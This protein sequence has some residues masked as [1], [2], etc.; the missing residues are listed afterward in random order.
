MQRIKENS[1]E[2]NNGNLGGK[3]KKI[4]FLLIIVLLVVTCVEKPTETTTLGSVHGT[5]IDQSNNLELAGV[6]VS[7]QNVGNRTTDNNGYYE[8]KDLEEDIYTIEAEKAGYVNEIEQVEIEA[9]KSKIVN[10]TLHIAQPAQLVVSP[11]SLNFGQ[12]VYNLNISVNNGGDEEL[13]WQVSSDQSWLYTFPTTG[14]TTTETDEIKATVNRASL[15][16]GNY[17]GNLSFTSN[18]GDFN[19]PIQMVVTPV[20]MNVLPTELDFGES[21]DELIFTITAIGNGELN[22]ELTKDQNWI[23]AVPTSGTLTNNYEDIT[24]N[25]DRNELDPSTYEGIISIE[26]NAGNIN[27]SIYIIVADF[28]PPILE[29]PDNITESSMSLTWSVTNQDEI[30]EYRLYRSENPGVTQNSSLV[31]TISNPQLMF[32]NDTD[33]EDGTTYYYRVYSVS[34]FKIEVGSNEVNATTTIELGTWYLNTNLGDTNLNSVCGLNDNF[35]ITVGSSFYGGKIFK[36]NGINWQQDSY[37][38]DSDFLDIEII[39]ENNIW[40]LGGWGM[41]HYNGVNWSKILNYGSPLY[42]FYYTIDAFNE[43][44]IIFGGKNLSEGKGIIGTWDGTN[45]TSTLLNAERIV[46]VK[47]QDVNN[48]W[49]LDENGKVFYYNGYG[50]TEIHNGVNIDIYD[51]YT[52]EVIDNSEI[53]IGGNDYGSSKLYHLNGTIWEYYWVDGPIY[54]IFAFNSTNV[55]FASEDNNYPYEK[56]IYFWNGNQIVNID[57]PSDLGIYGIYF[58]DQ[59]DGWAVGEDGVVLRYHK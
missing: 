57:T 9:N 25:V 28:P 43:D 19:V 32:Y 30:E 47:I 58:K 41:Y 14:T 35:I 39:S 22:W 18:G 7:I 21:E 50:W 34:N 59:T 1:V 48:A 16:V 56:N 53:W 46:D 38:G 44:E 27:V 23:S 5:V 17:S 55:W 42:E 54:D 45:L 15:G 20:V 52:F 36:Y 33:L 11:T 2:I 51:C 49:A 4:Y 12:T 26:S 31:T 3:M 10:F 29:E 37:I 24:V 8:F 6:T 13:S 40:I